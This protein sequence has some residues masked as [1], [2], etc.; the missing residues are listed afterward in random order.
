M[1]AQPAEKPAVINEKTLVPL[2]AIGAAVVL[3]ALVMTK[4]NQIE[5]SIQR[6]VDNDIART[7]DRWT[8]SNM[9]SWVDKT[10]IRNP[11]LNLPE[12]SEIKVKK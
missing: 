1:S 2:V 10:K 4:L 5:N 6:L 8:A 3:T 12:V 7:S 11:A 9:E